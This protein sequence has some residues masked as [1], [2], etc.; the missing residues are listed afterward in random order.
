MSFKGGEMVLGRKGFG[1]TLAVLAAAMLVVA[2]LFASPARAQGVP[3]GVVVDLVVET[4]QGECGEGDCAD[5]E[6][7]V[8]FTVVPEVN[9]EESIDLSDEELAAI[10]AVLDA[11]EFDI[12]VEDS[13]GNE[14]ATPEDGETV[15]LEPG[16]YNA[17]AA[18]ADETALA[19]DIADA[20]NDTDPPTD[21]A[22]TADDI[23][24]NDFDDTFTVDECDGEN[25]EEAGDVNI[26]DRD[27]TNICE[28]VVNI[29]LTDIQN[30]DVDNNQSTTVNATAT[31]S[32]NSGNNTQ[33]ASGNASSTI[34]TGDN[35]NT[36]GVVVSNEQV[37]DIAQELNVSPVIVQQCIQLIAGGDID[38]DDDN[39]NDDNNDNNNDDDNNNDGDDNDV[40]D[41]RSEVL[42]AS[43]PEKLL[44]NTG[45]ITPVA[46]LTVLALVLTVTALS[47]GY[48]VV[49]RRS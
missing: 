22:L 25:G 17:T 27:Q 46:G 34:N 9:E 7:P 23:V 41:D 39:N 42:A 26:D 8:T 13:E 44:P 16:E 28:N 20:V 37:V 18:P 6:R 45:G 4:E 12:T 32:A 33:T 10:N 29:I 43:I 1:A 49:R 47:V 11:A 2:G 40:I 3:D 36:V 21:P 35:T 19:E 24:I 14:V 38:I 5:N 31:Q 15:C 48:A 30:P